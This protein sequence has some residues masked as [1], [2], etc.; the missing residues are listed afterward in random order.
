MTEEKA[1]RGNWGNWFEF[2]FSIIGCMV[3]LGNV[4]RFPYVCYV[5]GG[6]AFLIPYLIAMI[7]CGV[8]LMFLELAYCQFSNLGPGRVWVVCPLFKG[9]GFGM[10]LLTSM[11]SIYYNVIISWAL[12]YLA[13]SFNSVL[14]W[15]TCGNSWNSPDCIG[16]TSVSNS[17]SRIL[18][19][20]NSSPNST[21]MTTLLHNLTA[22]YE[23]RKTQSSVEQY[24]NNHVLQ[25]TD[26]IDNLGVIRWELLLCLLAA[27]LISFICLYKD[28]KTSGKVMYVAAILPY[29]VLFALLIRGAILPGARDGVIFYL[30]PRWNK[31]LEWKVWMA[32]AAQV[33]YS[34][35]IGVGGVSTLASFNRF[36]NNCYRDAMFLPILDA[37]TSVFSGFVIFVYLGYMAHLQD[38]TVENV[39]KQGAGLAFIAYPDG[40]ASMPLPQL[41]S[42]L[43]FLVLVTVGLDSQF[44]HVQTITTCIVDNFPQLNQKK[45]WLTL[46]VCVIGFLMGIPFVTQGGV[47]IL[48]LWDWYVASFSIMLLAATE[49]LVLSWIYGSG[50][51]YADIAMMIGYRPHALWHLFW[52]VLSPVFVMVTW[53]LGILSWKP[54]EGYPGWTVGFGILIGL[55]PL[56]PIPIMAVYEVVTAPGGS[57]LEKIRIRL[58][59]TPEWKPALS[60]DDGSSELETLRQWQ[61]HDDSAV[62]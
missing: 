38:T 21:E 1:Q 33:F 37:L 47:H 9:I 15:T 23:V 32:A 6:A 28:I 52:R 40:L 3:G 49:C 19:E 58:R 16:T 43:F 48:T 31:L 12:Y 53:T 60:K 62:V 61:H 5:N 25:L 46:A 2:F 54:L 7:L 8:P 22:T 20:S 17:S 29:I 13:V 51:L 35:G 14:P 4:W 26:S 56:T 59:P 39:V 55:L 45:R 44:V 34:A 18:L 41:W 57:C 42:V 36:H 27:W 10:V 50:K 24:W 30:V 11:G